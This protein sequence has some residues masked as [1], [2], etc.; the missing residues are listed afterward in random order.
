MKSALLRELLFWSCVAWLAA[1]SGVCNAEYRSFNP[2]GSVDGRGMLEEVLSR[3]GKP[4]YF[5]QKYSNDLATMCHEAT[6]ILAGEASKSAGGNREAF[7]IGDGVVAVFGS[8]RIR[9]TDVAVR[10]PGQ[11]RDSL[12]YQLYCVQQPSTQPHVNAMP[13]Y[14]MDEW[15]ASINGAQVARELRV[16]D[17]G[18][19]QMANQFCFF[20]D[21]ML[22]TIRQMDPQYHELAQLEDFI[23]FQKKRVLWLNSLQR[24][25]PLSQPQFA[26][27]SVRGVE[28]DS[29]RN[30]R[31]AQQATPQYKPMAWNDCST[32]DCGTGMYDDGWRGAHVV[33][34]K[35][36][37]PTQAPPPQPTP[38]APQPVGVLDLRHPPKI[39]S[40]L[41]DWD[42]PKSKQWRDEHDLRIEKMIDAK[43]AAIKPCQCSDCVSR[44][45]LTAAIAAVQLKPGPQG[46]PGPA[47]PQGPAGAVPQIEPSADVTYYVLVAD[48]G[49]GYWARLS[50]VLS[51]AKESYSQIKVSPPP[52][53][54]VGQLPQL[55]A[56]SSGKPLGAFKGQYA[57]EQALNLIGRGE[58]P[59]P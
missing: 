35:P 13:L 25:S 11:Y 6:H 33:T 29:W 47:G 26:Q 42:D 15:S 38:A 53:F 21:T 17:T 55:V 8:P 58:T 36:P 45:E 2:P 31:S 23:G 24:N 59:K 37:T 27:G 4:D 46:P 22:A 20:A 41:V 28:Y 50:G 10:V 54:P 51:R 14:L 7:Y 1:G 57:V 3:C 19:L 56:Y 49:A 48:D 30:E 40:V 9:I 5:R 43:L 18:D 39:M 52:D 44:E 32:G 34:T 12:Y 16:S